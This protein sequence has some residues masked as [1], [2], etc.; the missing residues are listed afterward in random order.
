VRQAEVASSQAAAGVQTYQQ[1]GQV[2]HALLLLLLQQ[3]HSA[4]DAASRQELVM[5]SADR[6]ESIMPSRSDK[7]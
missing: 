4:A 7:N 5:P 2:N 6:V 3:W 1:L